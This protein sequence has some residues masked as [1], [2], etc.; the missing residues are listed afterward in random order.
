MDLVSLLVQYLDRERFLTPEDEGVVS[1]HEHLISCQS[2]PISSFSFVN[3]N[4]GKGTVRVRPEN[5]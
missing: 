5:L 4:Q 3:P 1:N 2:L